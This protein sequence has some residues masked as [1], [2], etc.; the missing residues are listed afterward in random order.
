MRVKELCEM[1]DDELLML[2]MKEWIRR[3]YWISDTG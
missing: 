1:Q 3:G 2:T